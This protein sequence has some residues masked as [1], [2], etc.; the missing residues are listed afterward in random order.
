MGVST[1]Q[2][3]L[4]Y[5]P[6]RP[7]FVFV[8]ELLCASQEEVHTAFCITEGNPLAINGVLTLAGLMEHAAQT[9]AMRAGWIQHSLKQTI[10]IG[11][12]GAI[13]QM[14][15]TRLPQVGERLETKAKVVQEVANISLLDC[16]TY[17]GDEQ[18]C[19]TTI[20]LALVDE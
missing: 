19:Q 18:I 13:K 15:A 4:T 11:Y 2:D 7:P 16:T 1:K 6:Q 3:I 14:Q 8:D 9:C 17:V 5:I 20:K 12:I 10:R